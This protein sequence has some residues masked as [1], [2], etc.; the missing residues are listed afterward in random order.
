LF[1]TRS[2]LIRG[3]QVR[4]KSPDVLLVRRVDNARTAEPSFSLGGFLRQYVVA[5]RFVPHDFAFSGGPESL[6]STTIGLDFRHF[7]PPCRGRHS[8]LRF[9]YK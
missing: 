1:L 3:S 2:P 5:E 6:R 9:E 8:T 7:V 4:D